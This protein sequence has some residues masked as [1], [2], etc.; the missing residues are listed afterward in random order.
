LC[1]P[2]LAGSASLRHIACAY[3]CVPRG[4]RRHAAKRETAHIHGT[5]CCGVSVGHH[6]VCL[7]HALL[8]ALLLLALQRQGL[9]LRQACVSAGVAPASGR[10]SDCGLQQKQAVVHA[11]TVS[12]ARC[13]QLTGHMCAACC[14]F[15]VSFSC[16]A[17]LLTSYDQRC[18]LLREQCC[19]TNGR[20]RQQPAAVS[21]AVQA[22]M[23]ASL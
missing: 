5:G 14:C 8:L 4:Y 2:V 7:L 22:S 23:V 13:R 3:K 12:V 6:A 11:V 15:N 16:L 1:H 17:V 19:K 10:R 21:A 18:R 20:R 9:G